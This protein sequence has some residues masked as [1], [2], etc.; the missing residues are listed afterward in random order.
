MKDLNADENNIYVDSDIEWQG[1]GNIYSKKTKGIA[2]FYQDN[3]NILKIAIFADSLLIVTDTIVIY[4][5][6]NF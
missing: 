6:N 5:I 4:L 2:N 1:N 3:N